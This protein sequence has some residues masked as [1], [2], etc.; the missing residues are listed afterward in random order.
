MTDSLVAKLEEAFMH[1]CTDR[2]ACLYADIDKSTLYRYQE[3]NPD[4]SDRKETL[5]QSPVMR[6]RVILSQALDDKDLATAN[7]VIDRKEGS[8]VT[9]AGLTVNITGKD[10]DV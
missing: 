4:F 2:E 1:G 3:K 7:R 6:A 9:V 5:K 10:A 8:K